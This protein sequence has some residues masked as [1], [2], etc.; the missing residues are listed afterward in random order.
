MDDGDCTMCR[1]IRA[2]N[3]EIVNI[4][5]EFIIFQVEVRIFVVM[6]AR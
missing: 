3:Y 5:S 2:A 1:Y 6:N 4:H